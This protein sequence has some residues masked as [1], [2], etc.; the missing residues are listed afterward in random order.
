MRDKI[1]YLI[2]S[3]LMPLILLMAQIDPW[4]NLPYNPAGDKDDVREGVMDGNR[5]LL[6]FANTTELGTE[7]VHSDPSNIAYWPN[8]YSG[9]GSHDGIW[10]HVG[11]RVFMK[12][13]NGDTIVIEDVNHAE[14]ADD[15]IYYV[16]SHTRETH[17]SPVSGGIQWGFYPVPG[18]MNPL[19][20]YP[21]MSNKPNSWPQEGWPAVRNGQNV[22]KF[23]DST[24]TVHWNGRFGKDVFK[25][26][27]SCYF[28]ANDAQDMEH[29][30]GKYG[31]KA[32]ASWAE[33]RVD[34]SEKGFYYYPEGKKD[35]KIGDI[36]PNCSIN[37]QIGKPWGGIG[38]R[39]EQR[40]YQWRNPQ[41]QDAIFWEYNI[42]NHSDY[43]LPS[44]YIGYEV[45]NAIGGE[46]GGTPAADDVAYYKIEHEVNLCFVW[47]KDFI[48]IGG[49]KEPGVIG[50]AFLESPGKDYDSND[51]EP[52]GGDG[53]TDEKRINLA[54]ET[55]SNDG[56]LIVNGPGDNPFLTDEQQFM[57]YYA[58]DE[59]PTGHYA[60]DEDGD[61]RGFEDD[62]QN[63]KF[64]LGENINDDVGADGL[65]PYDRE[66]YT[67][68]D[69][70]EADGKPTYVPGI[71]AEPNFAITDVSESDQLGLQNFK[72]VTSS[73]V[74]G[75][76]LG[77]GDQHGIK[78]DKACFLEANYAG[79]ISDDPSEK[80][81]EAQPQADNFHHHFSSG[82]VKLKTSDERGATARM[83]LCELHAY[84]PLAGLQGENPTAPALFRLTKVVNKIYESDYRF[85]QPP[86]MPTLKATAGDN[87]VILTWN[88][89]AETATREPFLKN[90]NDFEG[91]KIYR[92]TDK[93][94]SDPEVITD[95]YGNKTMKKPIFQ[96]DLIDGKTGPVD[97]GMTNGLGYN[98]GD[99]SGIRHSFVDTTVQNGR[100]YYYAIVAYD[101]GLPDVA[102]G[103]SPSENKIIMY[104][105][106]AEE[107]TDISRNVAIVT[108]HPMAAGY[109]SPGIKMLTDSTF[110]TGYVIPKIINRKQ[111]KSDHEYKVQFMTDKF[112]VRNSSGDS[113]E[114]VTGLKVRDVTEDRIVYQENGNSYPGR[115]MLP[116]YG[117]SKIKPNGRTDYVY[118]TGIELESDVFDGITMKY[119]IADPLSGIDKARTTWRKGEG[120]VEINPPLPG[121][122]KLPYEYDIVFS[123][124]G[125][126]NVRINPADIEN[127]AGQKINQDE[128]LFDADLPFYVI[129]ST[130]ERYA[131]SVVYD[132][133]NS[134]D[135]EIGKDQVLVGN[136]KDDGTW[137]NLAFEID[138]KSEHPTGSSYH[139]GFERGFNNTDEI[140]FKVTEEKKVDQE[141]LNSEMEKIKVVPNPY[142]VTNLMEP[143][144]MNPDFNQRR[145]ILFT[146]IPAKCTIQIYT[147]TGIL[148]DEIKVNNTSEN[149]EGF[150]KNSQANG[151]VKW[152]VL[153]REGLEIAAGY[154]IY[155]VK[156]MITG[157]EK[158]G[159]FAIIK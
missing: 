80:Y 75:L 103:I 149:S 64:D 21:A 13:E 17:D 19:G 117:N 144:L 102:D 114:W 57:E 48:P 10:L 146:H 26:D 158:V 147:I 88:D 52:G 31:I 96:C 2:V 11:A 33:P 73:K 71:G 98:L 86:A 61:W 7:V 53:L 109:V 155:H 54:E 92:A 79:I 87:K 131:A 68:P 145:K 90:K 16:Q 37:R 143:S 106:K 3:I 99:D 32:G 154:Y 115:N 136:G 156:S 69:Q 123:T 100:T 142:V 137:E 150:E 46:S 126:K 127:S 25:A 47:D 55:Y 97:F 70:G 118:R 15:T 67:G 134:G 124:S 36:D 34:A 44:V 6:R 85:A 23:I 51:N 140:S 107:I 116:V 93:Q 138:F 50:F 121:K 56:D 112:E 135:F 42:V 63:G 130:L 22:R 41:A 104:K 153:T 83:S 74:E 1:L 120:E 133:N 59:Y 30:D 49:G 29:Y 89:I 39:V 8:D 108:P 125:D 9:T 72:Y 151:S 38:V 45:D 12:E 58:Y 101:Y 60:A 27:L 82:M 28:V 95:L 66:F 139:V 159:K 122:R 94:M 119:Y 111:V 20:E 5:V 141:E 40:G 76:L 128:L 4:P 14:S 62:N 132:K 77:W 110:G 91:Y 148:V 24:G 152:D 78:N 18:Y 105:N 81:D 113:V 129:N 157:K 65:S 43:T 84:D 35:I